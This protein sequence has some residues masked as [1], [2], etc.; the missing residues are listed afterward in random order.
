MQCYP[1][2]ISS[3][4]SSTADKA[5]QG[6]FSQYYSITDSPLTTDDLVYTIILTEVK[7]DKI[8]VSKTPSGEIILLYHKGGALEKV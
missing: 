4:F 2:K 1:C 3:A 6:V 7:P 5:V 8:T